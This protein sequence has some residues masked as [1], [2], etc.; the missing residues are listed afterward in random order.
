VKGIYKYLSIL[1]LAMVVTSHTNNILFSQDSE[2]YLQPPALIKN[3]SETVNYSARSRKF[4]G[5]PSLAAS[6]SGRLW[7]VWYAGITPGEDR[8]NYVVVA[9]SADQGQTWK[10][11]LAIDQDGLGPV[12]AFDPQVWFDPDDQL[13]IFWA[14]SNDREMAVHRNG[15]NTG[16]W[17]LIAVNG[18]TDDP[19][20]Q[21]PRRLTNGIMMCKPVVLT[22]GEWLLPAST[23][24]IKNG[25]R[26]VVTDDQ[27]KTWYVRGSVDIPET[28]WNC[29]EHMIVERK[30]GTL[31]MLVRTTYGIGES[32]SEDRGR[33]WTGLVPS[34]IHHPTSRFFI[35][36]LVSGNL[37]LVKHGPIDIRTDRSSLMAFISRD[38][39]HT[40]SEGL[41]LDER[42]GVSYPDGQQTG[43]GKI[44]LIYDYNRTRDQMILMTSFTEDDV[45][46]HSY[47]G[48]PEIFPRRIIVSRGG[49]ENQDN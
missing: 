32:I 39:G 22:S 15:M 38:D 47:G 17:A 9:T 2:A 12:R 33:T 23:W 4:T 25:A 7:A 42:T 35:R 1:A 27:G 40:W 20:W 49:A 21:E 8:N 19:S 18:D 13:W 46:R 34:A 24:K 5:I 45:V 10:E 26:I 41:L 44:Y 48:L 3:P 11:V 36:R 29:D 37:L 16:V 14:Q 28:V 43:D 31:W 6:K 30:D